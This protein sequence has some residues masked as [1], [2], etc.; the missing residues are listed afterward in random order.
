MVRGTGRKANGQNKHAISFWSRRPSYSPHMLRRIPL[1]LRRMRPIISANGA[2]IMARYIHQLP[3]WPK[4][5]WNQN[6]LAQQLAAVR[7]RQG[8]LIGRMQALGFPL[9]EEAIV[10]TLTEDVLKSSEIEGEILDKDQVRSSIARRLGIEAGAL[11]RADRDVE[12]VVEMML[13]ATQKYH[14]PLTADRLFGWHASLFPAGR[15]GMA[16]IIVGAWRD[17]KSGPMQVVSKTHTDR[18]KVHFEAPAAP[19]L[20]A[21]MRSFLDWFNGENSTDPVLK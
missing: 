5:A 20:D 15:S 9:R 6:V 12:G 7:H 19:R 11:T 10:N 13:D 17:D 21:E 18:P 16:K 2:E 1:S 4:F 3:G 8:R 14:E